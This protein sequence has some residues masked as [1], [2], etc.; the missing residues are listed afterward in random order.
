MSQEKS[1]FE[2]N[3]MMKSPGNLECDV[4]EVNGMLKVTGDLKTGNLTGDGMVKIVG[5][6]KGESINVNGMLKLGGD[7]DM[8]SMD[9]DGML[10]AKSI[11]GENIEISGALNIKGNIN[12]DTF[13]L[14]LNGKS[15]VNNIEGSSVKV[16]LGRSSKHQLTVNSISADDIDLENV[17]CKTISGDIIKIGKGCKVENITYNTS[18]DIHPHATVSNSIKAI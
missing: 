9:M 12:C 7:I 15:S 16:K 17:N 1:I 18:L 3:G 13:N 2:V 10:K 6:I 4:V 11:S 5:N 14:N 8:K